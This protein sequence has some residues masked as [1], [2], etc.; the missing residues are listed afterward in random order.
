MVK[1]LK[2]MVGL[3]TGLILYN[4]FYEISNETYFRENFD[5]LD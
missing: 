2:K 3:T 4:D 1:A 5:N